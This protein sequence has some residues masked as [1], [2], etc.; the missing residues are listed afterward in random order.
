MKRSLKAGEDR[1]PLLS[2]L[3]NKNE[4]CGFAWII[5]TTVA[6][7][8]IDDM[9]F[10]LDDQEKIQGLEV[11]KTWFNKI[12]IKKIVIFREVGVL[13]KYQVV[14]GE[15]LAP[16]L[17]LPIIKAADSKNYESLFY[18]TNPNNTVYRYGIGFGWRPI[19]FFPNSERVILAGSVP[20][21]VYYINGL[22][23]KDRKV[24]VE[25]RKRI[26]KHFNV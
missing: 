10:N 2:L 24:F 5:L 18:W 11:T 13:K 3:F 22:I 20:A 4:L 15:Q 8:S 14:K 21:L 16:R 26:K 25:M 12:D 7:I 9:P 19:Y 17:T 6:H 23:N 1:Q